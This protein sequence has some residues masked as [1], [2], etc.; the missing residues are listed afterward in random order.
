[1]AAALNYVTSRALDY[2]NTNSG[3]Y[4]FKVRW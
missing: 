1:M 2:S 4:L 3:I